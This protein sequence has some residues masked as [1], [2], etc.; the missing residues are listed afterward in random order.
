MHNQNGLDEACIFGWKKENCFVMPSKMRIKFRA[1]SM[2]T[3]LIY[4]GPSIFLYLCERS[5]LFIRCIF[6]RSENASHGIFFL[7]HLY[8]K[9][10]C[11]VT[12]CRMSAASAVNQYITR[13][14]VLVSNEPIASYSVP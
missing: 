10:H 5:Q 1:S 11:I 6:T 2:R 8:V 12:G 3:Q 14:R 13:I 4:R 9:G 7:Y